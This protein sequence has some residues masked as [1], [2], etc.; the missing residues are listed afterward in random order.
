MVLKSFALSCAAFQS[1]QKK[2]PPLPIIACMR[3]VLLLDYNECARD[4]E[5]CHKDATCTDT[6]G[7]YTCSCNEGFVD[8]GTQCVGTSLRGYL[9]CLNVFFVAKLFVSWT[10]EITKKSP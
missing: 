9:V 7:S 8:H 1:I 5:I 2:C 3:P 4:A 6:Q 10:I